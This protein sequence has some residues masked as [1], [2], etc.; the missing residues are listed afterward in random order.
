MAPSRFQLRKRTWFQCPYCAFQS[1]RSY[2]YV[3]VEK[4]VAKRSIQ[5]LVWCERCQEISVF[6]QGPAFAILTLAISILLF[7]ALYTVLAAIGANWSSWEF[8]GFLILMALFSAYVFAPLCGRL[9][10]RYARQSDN[11]L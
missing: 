10:N 1:W 5:H 8:L 3:D 7:I 11:G 9:F 6:A 2:S 4:S